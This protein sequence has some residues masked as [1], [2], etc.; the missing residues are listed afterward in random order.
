MNIF[1]FREVHFSIVVSDLTCSIVMSAVNWF[2]HI[3]SF[4]SLFLSLF[5]LFLSLLLVNHEHGVQMDTWDLSLSLFCLSLSL[6]LSLLFSLSL[7][8]SVSL[9]LS[10]SFSTVSWKST[11]SILYL[12]HLRNLPDKSTVGL[13]G[14]NNKTVLCGL[15]DLVDFS[16]SSWIHYS[17]QYCWFSLC[18]S[19]STLAKPTSASPFGQPSLA[20]PTFA[21]GSVLVAWPTLAKSDFG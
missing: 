7:S 8:L 14:R 20:K 15:L 18:Q 6:S 9:S 2:D 4:L 17:L 21:S 12:P 10:L 3:S 16:S 5:L 13:Q 11:I 19:W 1:N